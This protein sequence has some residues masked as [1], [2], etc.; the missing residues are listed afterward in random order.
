MIH[1][2]FRFAAQPEMLLLSLLDNLHGRVSIDMA[3][4]HGPDFQA[5]DNRLVGLWLVKNGL[6]NVAIFGPDGNSLHAGEF[7][8]RKSL[9][10]A[11]GSYRPPT[12]VQQDMIRNAYEQFRAEPDVDA[13]RTFFLCEI[14][15]D[16]L[17]SDGELNERDFLERADIL[18]ALGQTVVI[19]N[20][21]P[22]KKLIAYF[23]DYKAP[24]IGLAMG[25]RKLR[26]ILA[27]TLRDN[28]DNLLGAFGELFP[29]NVRFYVYPAREPDGAL[30]TTQNLPVPDEIRFL[31]QH[32]LENRHIVDIRTFDPKA[33]SILH[34]EVLGM[35]RRGETGWEDKVPAEVAHMIRERGM[36]GWMVSPQS[37]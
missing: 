37:P 19:S 3:R 16:N 29:R 2:C 27:E 24:R 21:V 18:C 20:C 12:L 26:T 10:I 25:V 8:Y 5:V 1:A 33:L 28:P 23:S 13:D 32:L 9:L 6:S 15:L 4:L 35:I 36:F 7:L 14:T 31:Y 17:R 22:H 34:K 30:L 11:R